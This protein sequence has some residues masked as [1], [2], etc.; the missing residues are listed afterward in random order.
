M[1]QRFSVEVF[2]PSAPATQL[3]WWKGIDRLAAC[4][5]KFISL[6]CKSKLPLDG[7]VEIVDRIV[8][9]T[10][11]PV[12]VHLTAWNRSSEEV[13]DCLI[14]LDQARAQGIL[15]LHGDI[16]AE[17]K[18]NS[19]SDLLHSSSEVLELATKHAPHLKRFA[20]ILPDGNPYDAREL[21]VALQQKCAAGAQGFITQ[22]SYDVNNLQRV[23]QALQEQRSSLTLGLYIPED[24]R[25][26]LRFGEFCLVPSVSTAI[27]EIAKHSTEAEGVE[28]LV[29]SMLD[30]ARALEVTNLHLFTMNRFDHAVSWLQR[31]RLLPSR[32]P[33]ADGIFLFE[34]ALAISPD[35]SILREICAKK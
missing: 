12:V 26:F 31:L 32:P 13:K 14:G 1:K 30:H 34:R 6:T 23:V 3:E 33:Q 29:S 18:P 8:Q 24:T 16:S 17:A 15:A 25:R 10:G 19:A 20:A 5:P 4:E 2:Y 27:Q 22:A 35:N 28:H 21:E 9:R 11:L 7:T